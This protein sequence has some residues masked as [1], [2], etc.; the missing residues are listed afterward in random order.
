MLRIENLMVQQHRW[1]AARW[2][3]LFLRHPLVFPFAARLVWGSYD[4]AGKLGLT[5][6]ALED[7]SLTD[8]ADEPVL[9][10]AAGQVGMV[11]P[12]ELTT[13]QRQAW[14]RHLADYEVAP[15]FAQLERPVVLVRPEQRAT[16]L[17]Q[18]VA[19]T[20]LNAMTFKGRAE[21]LGWSRGSVIDAGGISFYHKTFPS[22]GVDVFVQTDGMYVGID[23]Y[24]DITLGEVCFVSHDSV[25]LGSYT[26]DEPAGAD[27]PRLVPFGEV[28]PIAF[29]EALG[30]LERIAGK[31]EDAAEQT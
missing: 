15:P 25:K 9:S 27:D 12:L 22:A 3:E 1:P 20:K 10:P 8:A 7:R 4:A 29:S 5:F 31:H 26:Y 19:G 24:S 23:M 13:E 18:E 21:R 14:L 28:A 17:G 16:R 11:H 6:R 2:A 30:D